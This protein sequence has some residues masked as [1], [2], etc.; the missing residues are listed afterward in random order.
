MMQEIKKEKFITFLRTSGAEIL[1]PTSEF[2]VVR[3]RTING[4]SV[5]YQGKRGISFTGE[6]KSA[7][8]KMLAGNLWQI[9]PG[10]LKTKKRLLAEVMERD[11]L[12]CFYCGEQTDDDTRSLEHILSIAKGGNNEISNLTIA[13][14]SCN[15]AAGDMAIVDKIKLREKYLSFRPKEKQNEHP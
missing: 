6:S 5:V 4:V 7:Y 13:C 14:V 2:E 3:F 1:E 8:D 12:D 15:Q 10:R 11:G 9:E